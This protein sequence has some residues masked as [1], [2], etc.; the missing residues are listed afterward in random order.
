MLSNLL[1]SYK[2][3]GLKRLVFSTGAHSRR[4]TLVRRDDHQNGGMCNEPIGDVANT[5]PHPH[6]HTSSA[7]RAN[8]P[9]PSS[10]STG[11][12]RRKT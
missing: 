11:R 7:L 4:H 5:H 6:T 3:D 9:P 2:D 8:V 1:D 10:D 12:H